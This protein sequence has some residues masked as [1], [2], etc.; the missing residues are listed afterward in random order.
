VL[1]AELERRSPDRMRRLHRLVHDRVVTEIRTGI[2]PDREHAAQQLLYLH[3]HSPVTAAIWAVRSRGVAA[4]PGRPEDH[5]QVVALVERVHGPANA[6]LTRRWLA[7]QPDALQVVR[8]GGRVVAFALG[9]IVPTGSPLER[10][11]PIVRTALAHVERTGPARPGERVHVMR[12]MSGTEGLE[13]DP[14]AVLVSSVDALTTWLT[15]PLAW[16]FAAPTDEEFWGPFFDYIALERITEVS[17]GG[18]RHVLHGIDWRRLSPD[19]WMDLMNDRERTGESGPPPAHLLRPAPLGRE[20]FAAAVRAALRD[21]HRDDRLASSPL[22][23]TRLADSPVG[24]GPAALRDSL[25]R[26]VAAVGRRPR[27]AGLQRVLDRTFVR[28][29]PTQE[30]AAEVLGLPF[31]TY[32]RHLATALD[33][34]VELLWAVEIGEISLPA[35]NE[36]QLSTD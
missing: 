34:L 3:R 33:E 5:P 11:D 16:S 20:Q 31:S 26:G 30:A 7:E 2:G 9:V 35:A 23:G 27:G 6:E 28:A 36:Q 18:R 24:C 22:L 19:R 14:Y 1:T 15:Q 13:R 32:R 12:S 4:S 29:A 10:E 21:L 8:Q 25:L 17:V